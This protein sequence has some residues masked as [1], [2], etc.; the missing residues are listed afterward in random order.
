MKV[1]HLR[2]TDSKGTEK[3]GGDVQVSHRSFL[4]ANWNIYQML[5]FFSAV[6]LP[7][8]ATYHSSGNTLKQHKQKAMR[9]GFFGVFFNVHLFTE[10]FSSV[11][12]FVHC[13][14]FF[15]LF[16]IKIM[17]SLFH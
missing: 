12:L 16:F 9:K 11:V 6:P 14:H 4:G 15:S 7:K 2:E 10:A 5:S 3:R 8:D 1:Y 13:V 17:F